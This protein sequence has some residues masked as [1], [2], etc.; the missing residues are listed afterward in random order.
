MGKLPDHTI[1]VWVIGNHL[2]RRDF[3]KSNESKVRTALEGFLAA[4]QLPAFTAKPSE[5]GDRSGDNAGPPKHT[6]EGR[7]IIDRHLLARHLDS[8]NSHF[9][10]ACAIDVFTCILSHT[11]KQENDRRQID[12]TGAGRLR[13]RVRRD[14]WRLRPI[15]QRPG[16]I[17]VPTGCISIRGRV[18]APV[19]RRVD[20]QPHI[21]K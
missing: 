11:Y 3:A 16:Q 20:S 14:V 17:L 19:R 15:A 5:A 8:V 12:R 21:R 13:N 6:I 7:S 4:G 1:Y 18:N 2:K 10:D 9:G